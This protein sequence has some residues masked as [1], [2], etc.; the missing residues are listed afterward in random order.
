MKARYD[1]ST[2]SLIVCLALIPAAA[3]AQLSTTPGYTKF[4]QQQQAKL[5]AWVGTWKC[6]SN[7]PSK[8]PDI[9]TTKQEGNFFV[10]RESGDSPNTSYTRWSHSYK[11]FYTVEI[12]DAGGTNVS[13][14]NSLDPFNASWTTVFP[15]HN[16]KG[17]P[18]LPYTV[19]MT[20]TMISSKG[21]Y[22]DEN[23]GALKTSSGTCTK[24]S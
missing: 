12:D 4:D 2:A 11:M 8:K 7:P 19:T 22:Y 15:S 3:P 1:L 10:T 23:T 6:I 18:F 24:T 21:Q 17:R 13:S 16:V 5:R 20:G 9:Q 14:T